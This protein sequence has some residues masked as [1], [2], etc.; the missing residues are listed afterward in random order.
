[1]WRNWRIEATLLVWFDKFLNLRLDE[2]AVQKT[3]FICE[4][5]G[6]VLNHFYTM[7]SEFVYIFSCGCLPASWTQPKKVNV[8]VV[9][10]SIEGRQFVADVTMKFQ[11]PGGC[12]LYAQIRFEKT[13][14]FWQ[15]GRYLVLVGN[16]H[17]IL[18]LKIDSV[19]LGES[20]SVECESRLIN[21][22]QLSRQILSGSVRERWMWMWTNCSLSIPDRYHVNRVLS[23]VTD[24]NLISCPM[25]HC[26]KIEDHIFVIVSLHF[27]G[28]SSLDGYW[29]FKGPAK[30]TE[31]LEPAEKT[32]SAGINR[33]GYYV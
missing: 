33:V 26:L 18:D 8:N 23:R 27:N 19:G 9:F 6:P 11:V 25:F 30:D 10:T 24:L 16:W 32:N 17:A 31:L 7:Y 4:R 15:L 5:D 20:G 29:K 22:A 13:S 12:D 28:R 3:H 2:V 1:M 21:R 14:F